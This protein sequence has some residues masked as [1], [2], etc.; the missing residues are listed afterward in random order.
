MSFL[1][2]GNDKGVSLYN[3][4][5][6]HYEGV[7]PIRGKR[8]AEN[9]RPIGYR[10]RTWERIVEDVRVVNGKDETWYGYRLYETD[11]VMVSP[12]GIIEFRTGGWESM[13]TAQ[14]IDWIG[15]NYMDRLFGGRKYKNK[16]WVYTRHGEYPIL[17]K[18]AFRVGT[19]E[20]HEHGDYDF[21]T[22]VPM[23]T[24]VQKVPVIDRKKMKEAMKPYMPMIKYLNAMTKL[25]GGLL[26]YD[27]RNNMKLRDG[28]S[29]WRQSFVYMFSVGCEI[30]EWLYHRHNASEAEM[31]KVLDIAEN[32]TEDDWMKLLCV[33]FRSFEY[34]FENVGFHEVEVSY[35]TAVHINKVDHQDITLLLSPTSLREKVA[36]WV[37]KMNSDVWTDKTVNHGL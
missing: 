34:K 22:I 24:I 32:G 2:K 37:K 17:A 20:I 14:F 1:F 25:T 16:I 3:K 6:A 4:V 5:K 35:G 21:D 19:G 15:R 12:T 28:E 30:E 23:E 9:I 7:A 29:T 18:T 36:G 27:L 13:A 11:V 26:S 8:K 10:N 33:I 31:M